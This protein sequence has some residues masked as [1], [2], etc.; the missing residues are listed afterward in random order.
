MRI[1]IFERSDCES[2]DRGAQN[3]IWQIYGAHSVVSSHPYARYRLAI[4]PM[5]VALVSLLTTTAQAQVSFLIPS[6]YAG[7]APIFV[8]DFNG[9]GKPDIL[10][11]DGVLNL[12]NGDG[13]FNTGTAV[14]GEPLAVADF[15]GDGKPDVL[16]QATGAL[17]VLLGNGDG[18]FQAAITTNSGAS[19][20]ALT[21]GDV[22]G[23]G[24]PDVLGLFDNSLVVYLGQGDGTFAEGVS[25]AVGDTS[26]SSPAITLGDFNGD[27]IIDVAVSLA[28]N[29]VAGQEVVLLGNGDG[30]FWAG[31]SSA[32]V[33]YPA[34]VVAGDFNG[35]GKAD[36]MIAL[37]S[38]CIVPCVTTQTS[39]LRGNG[40]GTFQAPTTML[41]ATGTLA[42]SDV[43][44]DG[45]LDLV[46]LNNQLIQIFTGN[47]DGTFTNTH[48]YYSFPFATVET[49][50]ALADFNLDGNLDVA[51]GGN[52]LLGNGDGTL[53][54]WPAVALPSLSVVG[55]VY[56]D[57]DKNGTIDIA[58]LSSADPSSNASNLYILSNDGAGG[59]SLAHT[60]TLAQPGYAIASADLNQDGNLDL[61]IQGIDP[62]IRNWS[63]SI[64]LGNT[65]GSFQPPAFYPQSAA[66]GFSTVISIADFNNDG[67]LDLAFA[68]G[69][70][71]FA[72]LLGHGDGAFGSP[73]YVF[74]GD[75]G[76]IVS[77]DFNGDGNPDMA[78]AGAAGLAIVLGNGDGTFKPAMFPFTSNSLAGL[79]TADFNG[80]GKADLLSENESFAGKG[81]GTFTAFPGALP[82][83]MFLGVFADV[84]GDGKVDA[85]G[86][87]ATEPGNALSRG[88]AMGNGDGTF[89]PYIVIF[90]KLFDD[91]FGPAI[92]AVADMNGD[93]ALD[94]IGAG[95][96]SIFVV[97]NSVPAPG[98]SFSPN[99][100]NFP[101]QLVGT[102]SA[103]VALRLTNTGTAE[104]L[105]TGVTVAGANAGE[106]TETNNCA[107]VQPSASCAINVTFTPSAA[108]AATANLIVADNAVPGSQVLVLSGTATPI[109]SFTFGPA[110]GASS[111]STITAGQ[112]ANF[113]LALTPAGS[114]SGTV[115]LTCDITPLIP[116]APTCTVPSSVTVTGSTATAVTVTVAT[117]AS[118]TGANVPGAH[119]PA[120][121]W[122]V[123]G[124]MVFL[125][126]GLVLVGNQ[127]R[128]LTL[129][130][131]TLIVTA[132][133]GC[134]GNSSS[135]STGGTGTIGNTGTPGTP[136]GTYTATITG[137]SGN[138]GNQPK[139]TVIVQ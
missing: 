51:A 92:A 66:A 40:D 107:A 127:R 77:A 30:T 9:D 86:S 119:F 93:G 24:K 47:G 101:A 59:L 116:L 46:L 74:D 10:T 31:K 49:G 110:S 63:Y 114:F 133:T 11:I 115:A 22:N 68:E 111:S 27:G 39:F 45:K 129:L 124:T 139:L 18:T 117:T 81:D 19:L 94:V 99:L 136:T 89:G 123:L 100:V 87:L 83:G 29:N 8:A 88:V 34:S 96:A 135:S 1:A 75:G 20:F 60:Y 35:D 121:S 130:A 82:Q 6:T 43:N 52:L 108:G 73:T 14:S 54:A 25:Y 5:M 57:F 103:T 41:T 98:T 138:L 4:L 7:T 97:L 125:V 33:L 109:P 122:P 36:L 3:R 32:G 80:D 55:A 104:L 53:R 58:A 120:G 78:E 62:I 67:K 61:V 38:S 79:F 137:I 118:S 70:D 69:N 48:S 128:F 126:S 105:V 85:V 2:G 90:P 84:N 113:N 106:F 37:Q 112:T 44:G 16:E 91:N 50:L 21:A 134:D 65:D 131:I 95:Q 42:A 71:A 12:G 23:D 76:A 132:M 102:S 28:G 72:V 15:N 64:L 56:G 17:R 13:T 26:V